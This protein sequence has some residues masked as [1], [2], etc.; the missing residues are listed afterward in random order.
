MCLF[1]RHACALIKN[2]LQRYY[3]FLIYANN[4]EDFCNF[5]PNFLTNP[6]R[7]FWNYH[8]EDIFL[9]ESVKCVKVPGVEPSTFYFGVTRVFSSSGATWFR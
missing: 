4:S 7:T 9:C 2:P 8:S 1:S 5:T 6:L 3:F